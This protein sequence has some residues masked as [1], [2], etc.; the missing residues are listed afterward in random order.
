MPVAPSRTTAAQI[1]I[2]DDNSMGLIARRTVLEELGHRVHTC[3]SPQDALEQC[4][5]Q[6]FDVVVTD[7]KMPKMNG[8]E[9]IEELRKQH[10]AMSVILIS[11]FADA[12]GLNEGSTGADVVLQK[13]ANEVGNL[14]RAVN[15]LLRRP[16]KKPVKSQAANSTSKRSRAAT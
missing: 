11:G 3:S 7:Y 15:R 1:L 10:P 16:E 6:R 14:I 8:I 13:S 5:K 12:L 9:F 4:D 2:V